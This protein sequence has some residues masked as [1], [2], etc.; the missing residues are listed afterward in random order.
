MI[1]LFEQNL[2]Q[3]D[4]HSS[5][6]NQL[7]WENNGIWYKADYTGYEGLA[8]Y[9]VSHLLEHSSLDVYEYVLYDLEEIKYKTSVFK[10]AKSKNFLTDDWQIITLERLFKNE[11]GVSL[12]ESLWKIT[13]IEERL[14][15]LVS[16]IE[17]LTGIKDFG[18]YMAKLL[19]I[20]AII[21]NEDR[22]MHNIAVLTNACGEY[23]LCPIFDN[24]AGLLADTTL[25][26]PLSG[27]VYSLMKDVK[28]KTI[29]SDFDEQIDCA[30]KLYGEQIHFSCTKKEIDAIL[31]KA[32]IY[33][34]EEV[35]RVKTVLYLQMKK[36]CY[37]FEN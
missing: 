16:Q 31:A 28:A 30:E 29:S 6:G 7:K 10:G 20:D 34:K 22:H 5:K 35:E 37:L 14:K 13:G 32:N 9:V 36:Y 11:R 12:Y 27:D 21:L 17:R 24:G 33:G 2:K 3:N 15:F 23:R 25:D 4:R 26:Y 8:E 18:I 1:E 19:T